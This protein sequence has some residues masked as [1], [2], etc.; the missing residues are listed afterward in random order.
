M[1]KFKN[2][3]RVWLGAVCLTLFSLCAMM[4]HVQVN[5]DAALRELV[6][7]KAAMSTA[8]VSFPIALFFFY[9]MHKNFVLR[10][11]LQRLVDRDRL[12]DVATRD[13][14]FARL[15]ADPTAYG[16]S[17]M[18]DIDH[19]K[20]INDTYG[21]FAGDM[22]IQQVAGVLNATVRNTDIV[23]RFGGEEFV[24]FLSNH[25]ASDGYQAAERL[26]ERIAQ[27]TFTYEGEDI[28]VTVSIGGSMKERIDDISAA[29]K[30]ADAALYRAKRGGRNR[31]VFAG[32]DDDD[33]TAMS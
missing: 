6:R 8:V 29:I 33:P 15:E 19:F 31:T 24:V 14:F 28:T 16:V 12:T 27:S 23:C 5:Y 26:R 7:V 30:E 21:H 32:S 11:E 2:K 22:V 4:V 10:E 9:Q 20:R 3:R 18:V 1:I 17:L 13:F 25:T